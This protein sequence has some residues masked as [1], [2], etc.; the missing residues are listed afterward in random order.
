M[1]DNQVEDAISEA[2][3][4]EEPV[5]NRKGRPKIEVDLEQL[6]RLASVGCSI[7]ECSFVMDIHEDTIKRRPDC[8]D[9]Y[10]SGAENAKVRLRKA[11]FANAIDRM[12]PTMQIWLSKQ[13]LGMSENGNIGSDD[14]K[15]LPWNDN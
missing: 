4:Q 6:Y 7:R 10:D 9:A 2:E 11:M 13:I 3:V 15:V 12:H 14:D 1:T 5:K 8:R